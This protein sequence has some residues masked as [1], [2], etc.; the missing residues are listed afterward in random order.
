MSLGPI[1]S[2]VKDLKPN[3]QADGLGYNPRCL[4]RDVNKHSAYESRDEVITELIKNSK[5]IL[6]FQNRMQGDYPNKYMGVHTAG[7]YTV[8]GD[9][10]SDFFNSPSDP[11]SLPLN[12]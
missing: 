12:C 6:T 9:A 10:G 7:H 1:D 2:K 3:P 11:V 8:G 4:S 5:D